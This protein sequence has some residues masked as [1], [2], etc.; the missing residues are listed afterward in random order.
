MIDREYRH[1]TL[2]NRSVDEQEAVDKVRARVSS[3]DHL[4]VGIAASNPSDIRY[5]HRPAEVDKRA[6]FIK[7]DLPGS[8]HP[9]RMTLQKRA[10]GTR[11]VIYAKIQPVTQASISM[12]E[13]WLRT[14]PDAWQFA[15]LIPVWFPEAA[16]TSG[17]SAACITWQCHDRGVI[18]ELQR[19]LGTDSGEHRPRYSYW[20][21]VVA[22]SDQSTSGIDLIYFL[23]SEYSSLREYPPLD[24][25]RDDHLYWGPAYNQLGQSP[26][27]HIMEL[28]LGE[29]TEPLTVYR[30]TPT[31]TT[32]FDYETQ[33]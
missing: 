26:E 13:T 6:D 18:T 24:F 20:R 32:Q 29:F 12:V 19:V 8:V 9:A 17:W 3:A 4:I 27:R 2:D 30:F 23:A 25:Q 33:Y 10:H 16:T 28:E 31:E 22:T 1:L 5:R 15:V 11:S 21:D 7:A 14:N